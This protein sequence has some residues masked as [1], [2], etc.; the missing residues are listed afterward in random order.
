MA[1]KTTERRKALRDSLID[2]AEQKVCNEGLLSIKARDLA[3]EA[4]CAVGAIYNVFGD[5]NDLILE[6]NGRTFKR[7]G[8]AVGAS[9]A[10]MEQDPPAER[11]IALSYAYL[12][13]AADH[14]NAWRAL[15]EVEMRADGPIPD[16]YMK[17]LGILFANISRPVGEIYPDLDESELHLMTRALFSSIHGI[18]LLGLQRRISGVPTEKLRMMIALI[19][20]NLS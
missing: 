15:F 7:L 14:T 20:R 8:A 19:L 9:L 3:K 12:D 1:Q 6:V 5:L 18:V 4:G 17:E 2:I 10:G 13:F 16:W 11:L